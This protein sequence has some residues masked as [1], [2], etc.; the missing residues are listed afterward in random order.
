VP[1]FWI[2]RYVINHIARPP[3]SYNARHRLIG[4]QAKPDT[5]HPIKFATLSFTPELP[6]E[7]A[8]VVGEPYNYI[9]ARYLL[10][11]FYDAYRL[12]QNE[13]PLYFIWGFKTGTQEVVHVSLQTSS[14]PIGE[15][16]ADP[17]PLMH[18]ITESSEVEMTY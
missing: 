12:L 9:T 7:L 14:E 13:R 3:G 8:T 2:D 4:L 10:A 15:G 17:S 1:G 6:S 5:P 11:D 16:P 18:A